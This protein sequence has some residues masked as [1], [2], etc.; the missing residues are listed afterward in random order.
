MLATGTHFLDSH[1]R[2]YGEHGPLQASSMRAF[3]RHLGPL[4]TPVAVMPHAFYPIDFIELRCYKA[5]KY[6]DTMMSHSAGL[7]QR[8]HAIRHAMR[9]AASSSPLAAQAPVLM[10]ASKT[11][12]TAVLEEAIRLGMTAFGENKVQEAQAKWPALKAAHPDVVLHLIGPLQ[13]NKAADAVALFDAIQTIDR[14]KIADAVRAAMQQQ[15]RF[16]ACYIQVNTGEEEQKGGIS[17]AGLEALLAHCAAIGLPVAGL[18]CIPPAQ[19][20]PAPH[21][22]LLKRLA[23]RHGLTELSMGMSDDFETAIRLGATCVRIGTRLF[24][25]RQG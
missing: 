19:A 1:G 11:Q 7:A 18:M 12:T 17:P 20:N 25:A 22:A 23:E 16:P 15:Q 9:E 21:F 4:H 5:L 2:I 24:G 6:M 14:P 8:L 10:G 3:M 13:S